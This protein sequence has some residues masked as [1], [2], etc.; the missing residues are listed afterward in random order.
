MWKFERAFS[1]RVIIIT[2]T[3]HW[4]HSYVITAIVEIVQNKLLPEMGII[5]FHLI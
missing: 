4:E 1:I 3:V 2:G 5:N